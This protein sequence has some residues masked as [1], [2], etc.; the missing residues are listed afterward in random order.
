MTGFVTF[1]L[2]F[3]KNCQH[4]IICL[5]YI[6]ALMCIYNLTYT[7]VHTYFSLYYF[8][9]YLL[10]KNIFSILPYM[11]YVHFLSLKFPFICILPKSFFAGQFRVPAFQVRGWDTRNFELAENC[12]R[13]IYVGEI[14]LMLR[15][16]GRQCLAVWWVKLDLMLVIFAVVE[17]YV[18]S[19]SEL[20]RNFSIFFTYFLT[21]FLL[22]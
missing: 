15:A 4:L 11:L 21:R 10:N 20:E 19:G 6:C 12:F 3:S 9:T 1:R 16:Y 13:V 8:S 18:C 17:T 7:H 14:T 22:L 5:Y 2:I